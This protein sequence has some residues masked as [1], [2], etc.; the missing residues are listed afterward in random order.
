MGIVG[1][2]WVFWGILSIFSGYV[3]IPLP[4]LADPVINV[5]KFLVWGQWNDF[6]FRS[7]PPSM[8]SLIARM[9]QRL[10]F[11]LPLFFKCFVSAR[12]RRYFVGQWGANGVF[13]CIHG[14]SFVPS[15]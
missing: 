6:R 10:R 14:T 13:G 11:Y 15:L 3:G 8:A 1:G 7:K 12:R 9:K 2:I 5:C 4:P